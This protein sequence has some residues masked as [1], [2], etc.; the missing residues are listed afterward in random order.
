MFVPLKSGFDAA[1]IHSWIVRHV[2]LLS[3]A[4]ILAAL[5]Y[6]GLYLGPQAASWNWNSQR[7]KFSSRVKAI[8]RSGAP[9]GA[10]LS[11]YSSRAMTV[12]SYVAQFL[13]PPKGIYY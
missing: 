7:A 13:A 3:G 5:K 2:P 12:L 11:L 9:L 10:S 4:R 1:S 6:L 8:I